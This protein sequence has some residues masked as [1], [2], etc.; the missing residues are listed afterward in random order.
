ME[1][2]D[3]QALVPAFGAG[4]AAVLA[5]IAIM[6]ASNAVFRRRSKPSRGSA[7]VKL[8][9]AD[10]P[11][12]RSPEQQRVSWTV[13]KPNHLGE[14]DED[15]T[16]VRA[17]PVFDEGDVSVDGAMALDATANS[18]TP[19]SRVHLLYEED[20]E[21]EEVTAASARILL[22][23][24]GDSDRGRVRARN[25]D[26][27]LVM[28][29]RS[30][31]AVADGMGG[32]RGG[33]IA[34][35]LAID[36]LEDAFSRSAFDGQI[37]S[38]ES[39][40]RRARELASAVQMTNECVHAMAVADRALSGMGTTLV[41][42]RFSPNKQRLY[43]GHVGDS[44]CYRL[45]R[46]TIRQLTTDH[47]MASLGMKGPHAKD[48]YQAVGVNDRLVIDLIVDK[49]QDGDVY[50]LCSDGLSKMLSDNEIR[51]V[52][53]EQ[54]DLEGALYTLIEMAND[55]GGNDNVTIVIVKVLDRVSK[56]AL[57]SMTQN[58]LFSA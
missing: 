39:V 45:R 53:V 43:V 42:A 34:S 33:E 30:L 47:T 27:V 3:V 38:D 6:K 40:P 48:L 28:P 55:R 22:Y 11:G 51:E 21:A 50:L 25:E 29:E 35:S 7:T 14:D 4:I 37:E 9:A 49:P 15:I 32:H 54:E 16:I 57:E 18:E 17:I 13:S 5:V 26:S 31:F 12:A 20:A 2:V 52:L 8:R 10:A 56:K 24:T 23:A 1:R 44:R 46:G 58:A 41:A 36:T 19:A